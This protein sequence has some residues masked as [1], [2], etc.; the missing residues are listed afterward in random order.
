MAIN[1]LPWREQA[2]KYEKINNLIKFSLGFIVFAFISLVAIFFCHFLDKKYQLQ[3]NILQQ[4]ISN[5]QKIP[6]PDFKRNYE[7]LEQK[8][9]LIDKIKLHN[10]Q[11]W[12][13]Y[14]ILTNNLTEKIR[15][16][17][18]AW[19]GRQFHLLGI[20]DSSEDIMKFITKI[21]ENK[22]FSEITLL[23]LSKADASNFQFEILILLR[24]ESDDSK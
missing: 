2:A 3:R 10:L 12:Q 1:L 11:F 23:K 17:K 24:A 20:T 8:I 19:D 6:R 9:V 7:T 21:E 4:Q 22:L 15:L 16:Q 14:K 18:L 13:F 5:L